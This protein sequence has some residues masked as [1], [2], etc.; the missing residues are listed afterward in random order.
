MKLLQFPLI[1]G[2]VFALKVRTEGWQH[3]AIFRHVENN[4]L[5]RNALLLAAADRVT[6]VLMTRKAPDVLFP[7]T[8]VQGAFQAYVFDKHLLCLRKIFGFILRFEG[9]KGC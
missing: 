5:E 4:I 7:R 9:K 6:C 3:G 2:S 8:Q 1:N